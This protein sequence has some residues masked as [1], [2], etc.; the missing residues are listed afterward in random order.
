MRNLTLNALALSIGM[1]TLTLAA[2][3]GEESAQKPHQDAKPQAGQDAGGHSTKKPHDEPKDPKDESS[4]SKEGLA[5]GE[6]GEVLKLS[7]EARAAA[8]LKVAPAG[9]GK[10]AETLPLYGVVKPNAERVRSVTARFPG[11][12]RSVSAKI[13]DS[14]KQGSTLATVESNESLQVYPISSPLAGVVTE[15]LTNPGEQ[16][17]L[18]PLFT[19]ADLSSVWVELA[20][21]PRDRA[22]V[23]LGQAVRVQTADGGLSAEGK[24]VFVSPLGSAATQSLTV[25]VL[26]DNSSGAWSPGLYVRGE[27][28][29]GEV[30]APVT[31]PVSEIGRAVQ[32]ECRDRSRMPS[33][34]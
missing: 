13:G 24:V 32:Q 26:I 16:A 23:Q 4:E 15:R 12:V 34:A 22:R 19:V 30:M 31:V 8:G 33:S 27:I 2:C 6:H 3:G 21:F 1:L 18:Q 5:D 20:L 29:I 17:E 10:I 28:T 25:R 14:V 11:V 7:A 9:P